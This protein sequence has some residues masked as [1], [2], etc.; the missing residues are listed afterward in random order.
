MNTSRAVDR[1]IL[2]LALPALGAL[3]VEP[4]YVLSDTAIVGRLGTDQLAGLA[5]A[6]SVLAIVFAGSN[7]LTYGATE[8][9][10]RR[11]GAGDRAGAAD[12]GMQT[13][14]LAGMV[15]VVAAPVLGLLARPVCR[16]FGA[17]GAVLDHATTYLSISAVGIPFTLITLGTQGV[18]RGA[19]NYTT[20]MWILLASNAANLVLEVT[21]VYGLDLG[22]AGSAWSTVLCQAAAAIA[23]L[24]LVRREIAPAAH[25]RPVW[26]E[27]APLISAGRH[28]LLRVGS[29]LVI[30]SG[31]AAL[32]ARVDDATLAAHQ[33]AMSL[34]F[35]AALV[36]DAL[37]IPAQTLVA[38]D[39]GRHQRASAAHV[40]R[41]STAL[42]VWVG[43]GLAA[44]TAALAP[45]LPHL[46]TDDPAVLD[47]ATSA[48]LWLAAV[49]LPGAIAF[50][51][52]GVLIGSGD[53]RFL[54]R[55]ALGYTLAVLPIA[56]VLL[57]DRRLGIAGIWLGMLVWMLLR[58]SVNH[59]R[60]R[61]VLAP[62]G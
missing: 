55:A 2:K 59:L 1:R 30:T 49:L 37:A 39:L 7:F 43:A 10:A 22:M 56:A 20:P 15:G 45:L 3:A 8:R 62:S 31:S 60:A 16:A 13:I 32:A 36:L 17:D 58:A 51:H 54:G 19:S 24:A 18:L 50:A 57:N 34:F 35:L 14:W 48:Q 40:A 44:L 46:F 25:G 53:Y 52:D 61:R 47:R 29:M 42:S 6:A 27:M 33:I 26:S 41:R 38:E 9:V 21:M 28:L 5:V 12:V 23:F 4:I 11:V